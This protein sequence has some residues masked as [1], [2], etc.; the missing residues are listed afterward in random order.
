MR[1]WNLINLQSI[2]QKVPQ[3]SKGQIFNEMVQ[4]LRSIQRDLD[5][6]FQS[7]TAIHN[8][9]ISAVSDIPACSSAVLQQVSS[10]AALLNNIYTAIKNYEAAIK[11]E[12]LDPSNSNPTSYFINCRN[13][14]N[15]RPDKHQALQNLNSYQSSRTQSNFNTR[16]KIKVYFVC[17]KPGCWSTNH[18][19]IERRN[20]KQRITKAMNAY[21]QEQDTPHNV[22][23]D[24]N[25]DNDNNQNLVDHIEV[26][27]LELDQNEDENLLNSENFHTSISTF[28]S[29]EAKVHFQ[30]LA[31]NSFS[32][33]LTRSDFMTE[34]FLVNDRYSF[35]EFHGTML[36]TCAASIST[37]G[38]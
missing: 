6:E 5:R 34:Y 25:D 2:W 14:N 1:E 4:N 30:K 24:D 15:L 35:K 16:N 21:I 18:S 12:Q 8:K 20:A 3:K 13:H 28:T 23:N 33:L 22:G 32:H 29:Q 9:V 27:A 31:K 36:D 38:Y 17:R 19:D 11:A 10:L 26:L 37:A 7:D